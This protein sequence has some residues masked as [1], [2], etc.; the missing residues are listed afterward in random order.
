MKKYA[1]VIN[2]L[3][4]CDVGFGVDVE[5]YQSIGMT[6]MEVEQGYD[7]VWYVA[8]YAPKQTNEEKNNIIRETRSRLYSEQIDPLHAEKQR[9]VVLGEWSETDEAKYIEQVKV[10][11]EKIQEENPYIE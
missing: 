3:N 5:F 10:L 4:Q 9:K 1:K 6:E 8:G 2:E 11:T 7:G